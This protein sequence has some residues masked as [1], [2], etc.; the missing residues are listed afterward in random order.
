[1]SWAHRLRQA[2]RLLFCMTAPPHQHCDIA[3]IVGPMRRIPRPPEKKS[4]SINGKWCP[5]LGILVQPIPL[6]AGP[7]LFM[8]SR[9]LP[10]FSPYPQRFRVALRCLL[11]RSGAFSVPYHQQVST[12]PLAAPD[13]G[14]ALSLSE[15]RNYTLQH[16]HYIV[17]PRA[18]AISSRFITFSQPL[19]L[20]DPPPCKRTPKRQCLMRLIISKYDSN[21]AGTSSQECRRTLL[22]PA[23]VCC[24]AA[25]PPPPQCL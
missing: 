14:F 25:T 20:V 1:M 17:T 22:L 5:H 16:S 8:H 18:R 23:A 13:S 10:L 4:E 24:A 7:R 15:L 19:Q 2:R 9:D 12:L 21:Y 3:R 6:R 11:P